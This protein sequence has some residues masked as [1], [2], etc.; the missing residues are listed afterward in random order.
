MKSVIILAQGGV[1]QVQGQIGSCCPQVKDPKGK[2]FKTHVGI[3]PLLSLS[4]YCQS[5]FD[6]RLK[7]QVPQQRGHLA[8]DSSS[9]LGDRGCPVHGEL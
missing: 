7:S 5:G 4:T 3:V 2:T 6:Y 8:P 1:G 9:L